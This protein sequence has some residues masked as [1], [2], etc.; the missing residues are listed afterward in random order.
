MP[1]RSRARACASTA[2]AVLVA[3]CTLL[4]LLVASARPA[5]AQPQRGE[6]SSRVSSD[7]VEV[8]EPFTVEMA[9]YGADSDLPSG[10]ELQ[11]PAG[12]DVS[13]PRIRTQV[14]ARLGPGG[15]TVRQGIAATWQLVARREG[16]YV[17]PAPT[18]VI[19]GERVRAGRSSKV[20]VVPEGTRPRR[21]PRL[22][23]FG[24]P[25]PFGPSIPFGF[26]SLFDDEPDDEPASA[27]EETARLAM[28][29][30]PE[31]YVFL[32]TVTDKTKAVVG[33][34]VTLTFYVY[35]RADFEM[36][37]RHEPSLADFQ[38]VGMLATPGADPPVTTQVGSHRYLVRLLDRVAVFPLRAG[39][40]HTGTLSA[41]F[42]G[43]R[44]GKRVERS[45]NDVVV[46]VQEP[47][48]KERPA[49]YRLGDVGSFRLSGEVT[50]REAEAG[51]AVAVLLRLQGIGWVPTSIEVPERVSVEWLD[52]EVKGDVT[53]TDGKVGGWRTFGYVVRLKE[54]GKIYLGEVSLPFFDPDKSVYGEAKLD[55]GDVLVRPSTTAPAGSGAAS[56]GSAPDRPADPFATV[57][58]ARLSLRP[59]QPSR[60][61]RIEPRVFWAL[62]LAPPLCVVV[63]FGL[64]RARRAWVR[65][66]DERR[67]DPSALAAQAL[68][69]MRAEKDR[70]A[71]AVLAER[72]LHHAIEGACGLKARGVL[73]EVLADELR[74]RAIPA[75][76]A[77]QVAALLG[78]YSSLRFEP[79]PKLDTVDEL[80]R[81]CARLVGALRA[82]AGRRAATQHRGKAPTT[83]A[84][85]LLVATALLL[86]SPRPAWAAQPDELFRL[87]TNAIGEGKFDEAIDQLEAYADQ[88][89]LHPDASYNRGLAYL[90]R[91]RAGAERP[92]D[93]GRAA[94]AFEEA[95]LLRT[96]DQDAE[97]ALE[98][99]QAEVARRNA[100]RG[101][102]LVT[103][104]PTMDRLLVGL[105]SEQ[106]WAIAAMVSSLLLAA[107]L[108]LR[109]NRRRRGLLIA[110][111][112]MTPTAAVALCA[113]VPL[114]LGARHIR[115]TTRPAVLVAP[116]I[117]L[118]DETGSALGGAPLAEATRVEVGE[119]RGRLVQVRSGTRE[120][121]IPLGTLRLLDEP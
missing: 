76:L 101:K 20:R 116:E 83:S 50:P 80:G 22:D 108:V 89:A 98:L 69:A 103:E 16:R 85:L 81:R 56:A 46:E 110:G 48:V 88:G 71:R 70:S 112:V 24:L 49:G 47:P 25:S 65:R 111:T 86:P 106:S 61:L 44:L 52:P 92:G 109:A 77:D 41:R 38:R 42:T 62:V 55:L 1:N 78:D 119:R 67:N 58:P 33:E 28:P 100:R 54:P 84:A 23:P 94:A 8:G 72:A 68:R 26:K 118:M 29:V 51:G 7:E 5:A 2:R 43:S 4:A 19:D 10:P 102:D 11:V 75:E 13:G 27:S 79:S 12:I 74:A 87:G 45:S 104:R 17:I 37:E 63:G 114:F 40:L 96:G 18:V 15:S 107:G 99:V 117:F 64:R 93:L 6:A 121:W 66:R 9:A 120:G 60:A 97:H 82:E 59:W 21:R 57:A 3:L 113:L 31:P 14:E 34:Q 90:T 105:A 53:I 91:V 39:S 36:T 35:Y 115:L 73:V 30:E 32:R 95:L